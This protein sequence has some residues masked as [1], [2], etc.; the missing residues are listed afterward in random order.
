MA[1]PD[2]EWQHSTFVEI[3]VEATPRLFSYQVVCITLISAKKYVIWN[4][5]LLQNKLVWKRLEEI[6]LKTAAI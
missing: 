3:L 6:Y 1:L 2:L 4:R 5:G